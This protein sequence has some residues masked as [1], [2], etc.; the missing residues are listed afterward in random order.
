MNEQKTITVAGI[1][2][3]NPHPFVL[4]GGMNVLESR[5]RALRGELSNITD[6]RDQ[7][8]TQIKRRWKVTMYW[9]KK[10]KFYK[11]I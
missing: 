9:N 3:A 4:F 6:Q 8:Q 5:E 2:V 10:Y 7:A 11:M 1:P